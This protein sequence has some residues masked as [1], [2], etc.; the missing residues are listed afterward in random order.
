MPDKRRV[1]LIAAAVLSAAAFVTV[2]PSAETTG[3]RD[4]VTVLE[5][6]PE[7]MGYN[8]VGTDSMGYN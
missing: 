4:G 7:S 2:A 8:C 3:Q 1:T 6:C 5:Q